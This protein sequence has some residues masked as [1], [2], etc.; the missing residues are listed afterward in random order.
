MFWLIGADLLYVKVENITQNT[1]AY[2]EFN[3]NYT[4]RIKGSPGDTIKVYADCT[5]MNYGKATVT[6]VLNESNHADISLE[7]K[8]NGS[9][10]AVITDLSGNSRP[11]VPRYMIIHNAGNGG[12]VTTVTASSSRISCAL[13][14]GN[15]K[16]V[17]AWKD[18]SVYSI[19]EWEDELN[20]IITGKFT[21]ESG[22]ALELGPQ[23][24]NYEEDGYFSYS[25]DNDFTS[26]HSTALPG[27]VITL[28]ASYDYSRDMVTIDSGKLDL[29]AAVP[30]LLI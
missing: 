16:A 12:Y 30:S 24:I 11:D 10:N 4:Y 22:K 8:L 2:H 1:V 19:Q 17:L 15:Y 27:Q 18:M 23:R 29:V 6:T 26:S 3:D 5:A 21:V 9:V 13:P 20:C 25:L 14:D 28:R 7:L